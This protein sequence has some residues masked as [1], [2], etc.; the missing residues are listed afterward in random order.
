MKLIFTKIIAVLAAIS[1]LVLILVSVWHRS[2]PAKISHG[3]YASVAQS[4]A[5]IDKI[6]PLIRQQ[7]KKIIQTRNRIL[8]LRSI[9][10]KFGQLPKQYQQWLNEVA[11][12]YQLRY[13]NSNSDQDWQL[14]LQ[15]VNII[16]NSLVIAQ[17]ANESAWGQ[18]RFARGGNNLFGQHCYYKNCGIVPH[19]RAANQYF[20]V[21]KFDSIS[22]SIGNYMLTL[23]TNDNYRQFRQL[24]QKLQQQQKLL[25]GKVLVAGLINYSQKKDQ[26]IIIIRG[27]IDRYHLSQ[28]DQ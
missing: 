20:E 9:Q 6:L 2:H 8:L 14:L 25:S 16:P 10:K 4:R 11:R 7:N 26:Y 1:V 19:R 24:R 23:N 15:R 3:H 13:W 21:T 22:A 17:A 5:F 27:I 28:Y 12:M 18:S